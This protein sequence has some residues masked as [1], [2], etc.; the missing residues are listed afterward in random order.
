MLSLALSV[1][2]AALGACTAAGRRTGRWLIRARGGTAGV[3]TRVSA[4]FM[5]I[6]GICLVSVAFTT[7]GPATSFAAGKNAAPGSLCDSSGSGEA[8]LG[9]SLASPGAILPNY[10]VSSTQ[11]GAASGP[12][13]P[14]LSPSTAYSLGTTYF[15]E[16]GFTTGFAGVVQGTQTTTGPVTEANHDSKSLVGDAASKT[17]TAIAA[18]IG[19]I[20]GPWST[21]PGAT[22]YSDSTNIYA[23]FPVTPPFS[24]GS[25]AGIN[26]T[27]SLPALTSFSPAAQPGWYAVT[28]QTADGDDNPKT[29][30]PC[31]VQWVE[32]VAAPGTPILSLVKTGTAV[33]VPGG[34]GQYTLEVKNTGTATATNAT[35]TDTMPL[36]EMFQSVTASDVGNTCTDTPNGTPLGTT[37]P[38]AVS[39]TLSCTIAS[40]A[41]GAT[42]SFTVDVSY[43]TDTATQT[44]CATVTGQTTPSC[45]STKFPNLSVAKS[46]PADGVV[47]GNGTYTLVVTNSGKADAMGGTVT[48]TLASGESF[49]SASGAT[50]NPIVGATPVPGTTPSPGDTIGCQLPSNQT[51]TAGGGTYPFSV[52]VHWAQGIEGQTLTDCA[53]MPGQSSASCV[54]THFP[55]LVVVKSGPA[56]G[57][58]GGNGVYNLV[59]T[60][61]GS[62]PSANNTPVTD[63]LPAGE[64]FLSSDPNICTAANGGT[65]LK[66]TG[67][68]LSET[69]TCTI[70]SLAASGS[71]GDSTTIAVTV[72]W[73]QGTDGMT[74]T[75]C[76]T[77]DSQSTPSCVP[78]KI[79]NQQLKGF[80]YLCVNGVP[81]VTVVN[82]GDLS[83]TGPQTVDPTGKST[84]DVT[85]IPAGDYLMA[86]TAPTGYNF[87]QCGSTANIGTPTSANEKVT[88]PTNGVGTGIFYVT[89][90]SS[91][92]SSITLTVT[93]ANDADGLGYAQ[94]ET[95]TGPGE[96]VP[97]RVIVTNTSSVAVTL[98]DI[99]DSWPGQTAFA[100][101]CAA[102]FD[103]T[104]LQPGGSAT[105]DF[106]E[107]N[108][109]PAAGGSLTNT[110]NVTGCQSTDSTN[111]LTV[112]ATSTVNTPAAVVP[113]STLA[114]TG[115]PAKLQLL[116]EIGFGLLSAG[117]FV[118]WYTRPRRLVAE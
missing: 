32:Q 75:D 29:P 113:P 95:S 50:C 42:T 38:G 68:G 49:V 84:L 80:I 52:V 11:V 19:T 90:T 111:C 92:K 103:G 110:V 17:P 34:N 33:G 108:Y 31:G 114:F 24:S 13:G 14:Q 21:S 28:I 59:V 63:T 100:P 74:L 71:P 35:V 81:S 39:S 43:G 51:I 88:V 22:P 106:T 2:R 12:N 9:N 79:P 57:T 64:T 55:Q 30:A 83:A 109:A 87:V 44:D 53:T 61:N 46:G 65:A 69:V 101:G 54:P 67:P 105:C 93:K 48:D 15:D 62:G 23:V 96:N 27:G 77:V 112:P 41:Q 36:D 60:N 72:A 94:T 86:A 1:L 82:G 89:P 115:P 99:S 56:V 104:T 7:S 116:L 47:G 117:M 102:Q 97:F 91:P 20:T 5:S 85:P 45:A 18:G 58:A 66:G 76:A 70:A 73:N 107:N 6:V 37:G 98:T 4:A 78:T 40:L 118:L 8:T 16:A 3:A 25:N 26:I 10:N